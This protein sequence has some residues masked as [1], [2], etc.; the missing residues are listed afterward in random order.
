MHQA[1]WREQLLLFS[2]ALQVQPREFSV[3]DVR[4]LFVAAML[5]L[6]KHILLTVILS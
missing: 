4:L 1:K 5:C 2:T 6:G 3:A